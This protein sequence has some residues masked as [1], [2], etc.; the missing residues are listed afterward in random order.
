MLRTRLARRVLTKT[1]QA[2]L[3][4]VNVRS[5][6]Q[7]VGSITWQRTVE[8]EN[9]AKGLPIG[10]ACCCWDCKRIADKLGV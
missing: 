1:E 6:R 2:H 9:L 5:M 3:T 10:L 8:A 4:A 7:F